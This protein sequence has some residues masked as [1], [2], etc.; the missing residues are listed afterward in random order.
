MCGIPSDSRSLEVYANLRP[1]VEA[2]AAMHGFD[3]RAEIG[4]AKDSA[5]EYKSTNA[6]HMDAFKCVSLMILNISRIDKS[7]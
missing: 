6:V 7:S 3:M 4:F 5:G 2:R 1:F